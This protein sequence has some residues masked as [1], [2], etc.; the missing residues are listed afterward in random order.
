M[1]KLLAII[2][3]MSVLLVPQISFAKK[4]K[5]IPVQDWVVVA[6]N[7]GGIYSYD[8]NSLVYL[9]ADAQPQDVVEIKV[10]AKA[11][12]LDKN[13]RQQLQDKYG[14]KLK[15]RRHCRTVL[16]ES[17]TKQTEKHLPNC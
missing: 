15:R 17:H 5:P 14:K 3:L 11:D 13:F 7:K 16:F 8:K 6:Q 1:K 4:A 9:P 10:N 12:I 2:S